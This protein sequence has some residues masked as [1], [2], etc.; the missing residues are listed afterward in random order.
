MT[1]H[2]FTRVAATLTALA[3]ASPVLIYP[4]WKGVPYPR[5]SFGLGIGPW[6]IWDVAAWLAYGVPAASMI[7]LGIRARCLQQRRIA[8]GLCQECAY[9]LRATPDRCPECGAASRDPPQNPPMERTAT[10]PSGAA[11]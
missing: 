6:T 2:R 8:R 7:S 4:N 9:D 3:L 10:A 5:V 11:G 1:R